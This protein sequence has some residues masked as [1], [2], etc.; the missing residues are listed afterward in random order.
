[1][2]IMIGVF[3][4]VFILTAVGPERRGVAFVDEAAAG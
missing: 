4:A 1:M 2:V 3:I